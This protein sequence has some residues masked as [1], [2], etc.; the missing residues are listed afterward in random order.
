MANSM[1]TRVRKRPLSSE[2]LTRREAISCLT[3]ASLAFIGPAMESAAYGQER[4]SFHDLPRNSVRVDAGQAVGPLETWRHGVG[5]GG[6]NP[7]PMSSP[8]VSA[9]KEIQ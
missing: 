3:T 6:V 4:T 9:L 8:V 2:G 1:T 5:Q 7:A